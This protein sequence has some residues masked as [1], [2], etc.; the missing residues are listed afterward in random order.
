MWEKALDEFNF[1]KN[2]KNEIKSNKIKIWT[3]LNLPSINN[4]NQ[5]KKIIE[6]DNKGYINDYFLLEK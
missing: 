1:S 3:K 6:N 5:I 2:V 4:I